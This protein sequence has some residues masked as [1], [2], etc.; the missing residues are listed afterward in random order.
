MTTTTATKTART[1]VAAATSNA[2]GATTRG[3]VDIKTTLGGLLTMK[4]T[5][6]GTGPTAQCEGRVLVAHNATLPAAGSAGADWKTVWRF[7]GGTTASAVTEQAYDVPVGVMGLE[8]EFT[9]NTGQA[10]TVEAYLSEV[11]SMASASGAVRVSVLILPRRFYG[12]P[13][14]SARPRGDLSLHT[15]L[16]PA[17]AP[18]GRF[19]ELL[20]PTWTANNSSSLSTTAQAPGL[21]VANSSTGYFSRA[22]PITSGPRTIGLVVTPTFVDANVRG[23]WSVGQTETSGSVYLYL[24]RSLT[25]LRFYM[26]GSY[27]YNVAGWIV[28]GSPLSIVISLQD[29]TS[30]V[31]SR[32]AMAVNGQLVTSGT[33]NTGIS[34]ADNEYLFSGFGGN[35]EAGCS[36]FW[37]ARQEL[38]QAQIA[39][40]SANSW[41]IFEPARR[42]F[43]YA[44][45]AGGTSAEIAGTQSGAGAQSG[46]IVT[47]IQGAGVQIGLG[48]Q[49]GALSTAI[50]MAGTV[51]G[52]GTQAG[53]ILTKIE[54]DG[55][56]LG[57]GLQALSLA[58]GIS[59]AGIL[60]GEGAASGGIVT[61]I[62]IT[63]QQLADSL[64]TGGIANSISIAGQQVGAGT[65]AGQLGGGP[66]LIG[67]SQ[68]GAGAQSLVLSTSIT[69]TGQ[70]IADAILAGSLT[71]EIRIGGIVGGVAVISGS[72]DTVIPVSGTVLGAG[73]VAGSIQAGQIVWSMSTARRLAVPAAA[74][75]LLV[76]A[77]A[78]S[79]VVPA[80]ARSLVVPS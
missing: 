73:Q 43:A 3:T 52:V 23:I 51:S 21:A 39:D 72:L 80:A 48:S 55:D 38:S 25:A 9:G 53:D 60:A 67:G 77:A 4:I 27:V 10:V 18:A 63:G 64:I 57:A 32:Y 69:L 56:Q 46:A 37:E 54:I 40:L 22:N 36:L 1:L 8:V 68:A 14:A 61:T 24:A 19:A 65:Q 41:G 45:A 74:R 44:F 62:T 28:A 15:V 16:T 71:T 42:V 76:P 29:C 49:S 34:P 2:A 12:Q 70:Q 20:G 33:I 79:L 50:T 78:R 11:T 6:G 75:S 58:T 31:S 47:A 13:P 7:G 26:G 35:I 30:T 17:G 66:A 5:N 59:V